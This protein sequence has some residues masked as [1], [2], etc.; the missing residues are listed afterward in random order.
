MD[1]CIYPAIFELAEE[2]GYCITFPDLPGC[3][4]EGN[5]LL[6]ALLMA[7]EALELFIYN[8][9]DDKEE[10]PVPSAPESIQVSKGSFVVPITAWMPLV[11]DEMLNKA[12]KKTLT[13]PKWLNDVSEKNKINFSQVLQVALKDKL[14]IKS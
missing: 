10:I 1:Q 3:I 6:E 14:N 8:L 9:E 13:I 5:T 12:V 2:G 7:K 4:S 11:R